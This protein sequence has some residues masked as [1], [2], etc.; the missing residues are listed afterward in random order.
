[1]KA[2]PGLGPPLDMVNMLSLL[3]IN[4]SYNFIIWLV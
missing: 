3:L 4:V 1:L 2:A